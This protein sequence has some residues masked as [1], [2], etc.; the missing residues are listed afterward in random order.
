MNKDKKYDEG[1]VSASSSSFAEKSSHFRTK[2]VVK[3][4]NSPAKEAVV[5]EQYSHSG[6]P[7]SGTY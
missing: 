5:V 2:K 1:K 6:F 3:C 4:C 7:G